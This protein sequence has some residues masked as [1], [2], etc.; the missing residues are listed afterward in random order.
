MRPHLLLSSLLASSLFASPFLAQSTLYVAAPDGSVYATDPAVGSFAL[1]TT[2]PAPLSAL[3]QVGNR[4]LLGSPTGA[5]FSFVPATGA[6]TPLATVASDVTDLAIQ[7][8]DLFVGGS[9]GKVLRLD[10]RTGVLKATYTSSFEIQALAI[11]GDLLYVGTPFGLFQKLDLSEAAPQFSFAGQCG[12]PI[13]SMALTEGELYL[14]D[15][16]GQVYVFHK[17]TELVA[18]AY[19]IDN[20]AESIVRDGETFLIGGSDG[21]IQRVTQVLGLKLETLTAPEAIADLW[22]VEPAGA[23]AADKASLSVATGGTVNFELSA[24]VAAAGDTYLLVGSAAGT[25]PGITAGSLHLALNPDAYFTMT[26]PPFGDEPLA[27]AFGPFDATGAAAAS[28]VLPAGLPPVVIG[29]TLNH[30]FVTWSSDDL[31]SFKGTS[32]SVATLLVP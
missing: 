13:Q 22:L 17:D 15:V 27:G 10:A 21:T 3:A 7:G 5:L 20:N 2:A 11:D 16:T 26:L 28:L 25:T 24:A 14:G 30:A 18:Y 19:P 29:L 1:A 4:L 8:G 23:L 12:G 9:N 31:T 6:L 32:N